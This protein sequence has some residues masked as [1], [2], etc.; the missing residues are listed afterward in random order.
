MLNMP[1]MAAGQAIDLLDPSLTK[2]EVF[3]GVPHVSVTGLPA[4]TFQSNNVTEGT[5]LGLSN[6]LKKVFT[7]HVVNGIVVMALT[8]ATDMVIE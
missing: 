6:D 7:I 4:G 2:W 3:I 8:G 1:A 5:P